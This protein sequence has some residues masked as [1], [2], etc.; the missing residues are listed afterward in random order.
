MMNKTLITIAIQAAIYTSLVGASVTVAPKAFAENA[1][2]IEKTSIK[3]SDVLETKAEEAHEKI[4]VTGSRLRRDSFTVAT[5]LVT[6][7]KEA[8]SD[9]GLGELSEILV[10]NMPSLSYGTSNTTSQSSVSN[11]GITTVQL[12][13]LGANRTLTLID[14]RRVVS[15]S[16]SGNYVSMSTIP[17]GMVERVEVITGGA[18]A[19]YGAD[20]VSG[21]V[22]II[23]QTGKEGFGFKARGGESTD[24]GEREFTLDLNY[25]S[26]FDDDRG[27]LYFSST[28]DRQYGLKFEDRERAAVEASHDYNTDTMQNEM[29]TANGYQ[30]LNVTPQELWRSRSDGTYGGVFLESSRFDK[31][32]WYDGQTLRDDWKGNEELYGIN[33]KQFVQLK[34]PS[35]RISTALKLD[36]DLTD[37]ITFY[38][39]VQ[40]SGNYTVNNKSPEDDYE[41]AYVTYV[42]K[43][44]GLP[45]T[46]NPGYIPIDNPYVPDEIRIAAGQYK[47]RI[48]WDR[49]FAE[50]GD[51]STDNDRSTIRGWAGLQG[52]MFDGEW[53]WDVSV[54]YGKFHQEQFRYN[55]LNI[56]RVRNALDAGYAA[57]GSIQCNDAQARAEGCAPLN[58]FGEGSISTEAA[59]YI[60]SNPTLNSHNEQTTVMGYITGDLFEMPAGPVATVFGAEYRTESQEAVTDE[61]LTYGGITWNLVP[62]FK[63]E[64][65]VAEVFAEASFPLL[66]NVVGAK[67]LSLETSIRAS[68]YDIENVGLVSSYKLGF[69]W[70]VMNGLNIRA[71]WATAQRAPSVNELY[72]P[73][74]GDFDSYDDICDGVS[75]TST[76]AGHD[77]CRLDPNIAALIKDDPNF[78][79][80]DENSGYSPNAGNPNLSEETGE[81]ITFGFTLE[82]TFMEGFSLAV[83]Y[84]DIA[85]SDAIDEY[86]N[87]RIIQECYDSGITFGDENEFCDVIKR[88]TE[89]QIEEVLQ[90]SYN[91]DE[92]STRGI[93][94]SMAYAYDLNEFGSLKFKLDWTHLL[95]HSNTSTGNEGKVTEDY[96]GYVGT[97]E[98][99][100]SASLAWY[101]DD[102][103]VRWSTSYKSSALRSKSEQDDWLSAMAD[104]AELCAANDA[105]CVANPEALAFQEYA[106][107]IKHNLSVSY[108]IA[109]QNEAAFTVFGGVNNIFD[110]K[111]QFYLGGRGNFGSEYDAGTGRFVYLGAEIT[112]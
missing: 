48:Y 50:V 49:R 9:T 102:L 46:I 68:D 111:G 103:R 105:A 43:E 21:V 88:D 19:T 67:H 18:S 112:F 60:R 29:L 96:V 101:L 16:K 11:T 7:G 79:F 61:E 107:Y 108:A 51:I 57:D 71:N 17:S 38:S 81:T 14:G 31:N 13:D 24:G 73:A 90:R 10:D 6:L 92:L 64:I 23:T 69:L 55:E 65:S 39:Q 25:G 30:P 35:D 109:L 95:E 12:R 47:D 59:D 78:E 62:P 93:D 72:E 83:D 32:Y 37:D 22:N 94:V 40:W 5:P 27:Y 110:D 76:G 26:T 97:F 89:G 104:N 75:A 44:T 54:G 58:L 100:A 77:N 56:F 85:I 84:Y 36:Y 34:V 66:Q 53:D 45:G 28:Y 82:P 98:D 87:N 8:I 4:T 80:E 3:K 15:N 52:T 1:E 70:Q 91:I 86:S 42:D 2:N 63:G 106:S 41:G 99:K 20:A 74:A 33:T